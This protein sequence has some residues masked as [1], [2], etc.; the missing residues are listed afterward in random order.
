[1]EVVEDV[2][3][4]GCEGDDATVRCRKRQQGERVKLDAQDSTYVRS[5]LL[6]CKVDED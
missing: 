2:V 1:M 6:M 3:L 5:W 4:F